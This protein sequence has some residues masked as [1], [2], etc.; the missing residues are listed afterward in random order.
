MPKVCY[1]VNVPQGTVKNLSNSAEIQEVF[2]Q[3][4]EKMSRQVE[5]NLGVIPFYDGFRGFH[6]FGLYDGLHLDEIVCSD[7]WEKA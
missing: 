6:T 1:S 4:I 5:N 7:I 2:E 3:D